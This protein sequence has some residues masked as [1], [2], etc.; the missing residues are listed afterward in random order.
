MHRQL[1]AGGRVVLQPR[2]RGRAD[3]GEIDIAGFLGDLGRGLV[4]D[5][6]Q[7]DALEIGGLAREVGVALQHPAL[8]QAVLDHAVGARDGGRNGG[9][10]LAARGLDR[11]LAED[12]AGQIGQ[13][14]RP[15]RREG[16]LHVDD[17]GVRAGHLD[18][19]EGAEVGLDARVVLLDHVAVE[20][21]FH[22]LGGDLAEAVGP[23]LA[24]L[25]A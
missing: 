24:F 21:E 13:R 12:R 11:F 25:Q 2:D 10:D 1:H 3:R 19:G 20:R 18:M 5:D 14:D 15:D 6:D 17:A 22:V 16:A 9:G 8:A 23:H 4:D 7:V